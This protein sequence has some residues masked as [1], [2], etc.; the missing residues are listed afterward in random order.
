MNRHLVPALLLSASISRLAAADGPL[1]GSVGY[2]APAPAPATQPDA[3]SDSGPSRKVVAVVAAGIAVVGIGVGSAFGVLA[4]NTQSSFDAHPTA[5][6]ASTG[7]QEALLCD[8]AFGAAVIA[9][10]TSA[11]LFLTDPPG[12]PPRIPPMTNRLMLSPTVSQHGGGA[13]VLIRF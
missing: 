9:G 4:M 7:N 2:V 1:P 10:V 13:A 8:V 12:P 6:G 3:A 11:V 5:A